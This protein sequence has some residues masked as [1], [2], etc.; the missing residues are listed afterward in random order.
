MTPAQFEAARASVSALRDDART[1]GQMPFR[2]RD[3]HVM[4]LH[5]AIDVAES[6]TSRVGK[7]EDCLRQVYKDNAGEVDQSFD[8]AVIEAMFECRECLDS[9]ITGYRPE[10]DAPLACTATAAC[11]A[12]AG[13]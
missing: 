7:L 9:G 13:L 5:G 6:A 12:K 1:L 10:D 2:V 3:E 11:R 8:P 4:R